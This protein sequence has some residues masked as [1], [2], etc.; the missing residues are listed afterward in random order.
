MKYVKNDARK[1]NQWSFF[2]S[3]PPV[4]FGFHKNLSLG[5]RDAAHPGACGPA[6]RPRPG[7]S[8]LGTPEGGA[9]VVAVVGWVG[10]GI[11]QPG[12]QLEIYSLSMGHQLVMGK[13]EVPMKTFWVG[14]TIEVVNCWFF[15][16]FF[17]GGGSYNIM[18][19]D[20]ERFC[21]CNDL[22]LLTVRLCSIK[23]H[24]FVSS[25]RWNWEPTISKF[26]LAGSWNLLVRV[27][28]IQFVNRSQ[29]FVTSF[30]SFHGNLIQR[31]I[32]I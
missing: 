22:A 3:P 8:G 5:H 20:V 18:T 11:F 31:D 19:C 28:K 25:T 17:L 32:W 14:Y 4:F 9:V 16:V 13:M 15:F 2:H 24:T 26:A 23:P 29:E 1:S 21:T 7:R 30:P 10:V 27:L 12:N 6:L